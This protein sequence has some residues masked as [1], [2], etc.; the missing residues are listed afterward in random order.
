MTVQLQGLINTFGEF[1][2]FYKA[3]L[4]K[5]VDNSNIA[6]IG[7]IRAFIL[8]GSPIL[9]GP[10]FDLGHPRLLLAAGA[11]VL[12]FGIMMTSLC[13]TLWHLILAQGVCIGLGSGA[14][15]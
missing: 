5:N 7:S 6:W 12:V 9:Y 4:L 8:L 3:S 15:F 14:F 1:Q 11:S 13:S 10:I 2:T